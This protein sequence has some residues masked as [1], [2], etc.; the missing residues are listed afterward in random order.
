MTCTPFLVVYYIKGKHLDILYVRYELQMSTRH[1][2]FE[3]V[4]HIISHGNI[5]KGHMPTT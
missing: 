3:T 1:D 5:E 2:D 4:I